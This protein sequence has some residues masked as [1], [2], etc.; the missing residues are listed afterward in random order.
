MAIGKRLK[1]FTTAIVAGVNVATIGV[2]ALTAYADHLSPIDHPTMSVLGL[3][4]PV[5][6]FINL[7][8]LVFW[9]LLKWRMALIPVAGYIICLPAISV[10]MPL[11]PSKE[12]P[13]GALKVMTYNVFNFGGDA[14][15]GYQEIVDF[16]LREDADIVCLQEANAGPKIHEIDST[17]ARR[18]DYIDRFWSCGEG[19]NCVIL[20]SKF[21]ILKCKRIWYPSASNL[22]AAWK[23]KIDG[24]TVIVINNHFESNKISN[25]EKAEFK[26]MLKG[27]LSQKETKNESRSLLRQLSAAAV[28]RAPQADSVAA[29]ID[30]YKDKSIILCG[31]F[32]DSPISYTRRRL[33]SKLT[34]CYVATGFGPGISYHVGGMYVRIDNIMCSSDWR[35]YS[36]KVLSQISASDHYPV[37]CWLKKDHK[38]KK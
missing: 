23:L 9:L 5:M 20:L 15:E 4:F 34:D 2:M 29:F 11:N 7:L 28:L 10:Y 14:K 25:D 17:L 26:R 6:L 12:P 31:D 35:P 21:P 19:T 38:T 22:S 27:K 16:I 32:N 18:Y 30:K 36:A 13:A 24:D 1:G 3:C 8:F 33:A 37:C